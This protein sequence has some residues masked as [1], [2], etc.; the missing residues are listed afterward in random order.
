MLRR[1]FAHYPVVAVLGGRQVGKSTMVS[2]VLGDVVSTVVFDPVEDIGSCHQRRSLLSSD[3]ASTP[4]SRE[5]KRTAHCRAPRDPWHLYQEGYCGEA[6]DVPV[7]EF[8]H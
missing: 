5:A 2:A 7:R 8:P 1:L 6:D 3:N 4:R